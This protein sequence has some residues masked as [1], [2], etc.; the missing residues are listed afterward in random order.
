MIPGPGGPSRTGRAP[1]LFGR[2]LTAIIALG[3]MV[4]GLM[5]SVFLFAAALVLG[6]AVFGW[7]WWKMRRAIRQ[8]QQDPRF[9]QFQEA[10]HRAGQP[11][12]AGKIIEGEVLRAEWTDQHR[13]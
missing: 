9:A 13:K 3:A 10:A 8:A 5:F 4:V 7:L 11:P 6:L 1:G 12:D 2:I